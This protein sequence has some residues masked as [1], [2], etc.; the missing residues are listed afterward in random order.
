MWK[1]TFQ[2]P[3]WEP[4]VNVNNSLKDT[5]RQGSVLAILLSPPS[6]PA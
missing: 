1:A 6:A 3:T 4:W 2:L 5:L